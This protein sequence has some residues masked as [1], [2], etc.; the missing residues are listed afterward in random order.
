M[1]QGR[2][3]AEAGKLLEKGMIRV[4][5]ESIYPLAEAYAAH[6]RAGRG[7]IQGKIVLTHV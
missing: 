7:N 3:L 6:E 2:Q 4:V 1:L 5:V